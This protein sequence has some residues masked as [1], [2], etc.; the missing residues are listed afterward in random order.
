M[1]S[2]KQDTSY[3]EGKAH[4]HF[5]AKLNEKKKARQKMWTEEE[6]CSSRKKNVQAGAKRL[7]K[8]GMRKTKENHSY[9]KLWLF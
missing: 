4:C 8:K 6:M 5:L 2:A 7:T 3:C 1:L 9:F